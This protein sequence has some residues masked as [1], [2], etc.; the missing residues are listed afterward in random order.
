MAF[1][2]FIGWSQ[3]DLETEL[4]KAQQELAD[5][6]QIHTTGSGD[7]SASGTVQRSAETRISQLLLAL[8][9]IDPVTY[10]AA[11]IFRPTRSVAITGAAWPVTT[12]SP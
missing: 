10:P 2:P 1:N 8:N 3:A 12:T 9:R 7:V 5:G 6:V 4:R 11:D